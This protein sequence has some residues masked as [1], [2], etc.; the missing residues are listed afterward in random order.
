M[1]KKTEGGIKSL[2]EEKKSLTHYKKT[3]KQCLKEDYP[4]AVNHNNVKQQ[5]RATKIAIGSYLALPSSPETISKMKEE[6]KILSQLIKE[7]EAT[8]KAIK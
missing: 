4:L 1:A 5:V 6:V 8:V 3:Y 2:K 7:L